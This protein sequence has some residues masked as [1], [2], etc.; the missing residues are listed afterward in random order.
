MNPVSD[1]P[2]Q[3]LG[4]ILA[5]PPTYCKFCPPTPAAVYYEFL[6]IVRHLTPSLALSLFRSFAPARPY[7]GQTLSGATPSPMVSDSLGFVGKNLTPGLTS[8]LPPHL[9]VQIYLRLLKQPGP[10]HFAPAG[11]HLDQTLLSYSYLWFLTVW[12]LLERT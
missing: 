2:K 5:G 1:I 7:L 3:Y 8:H 6:Q 11:P 10:V 12:V 9:A 4:Q